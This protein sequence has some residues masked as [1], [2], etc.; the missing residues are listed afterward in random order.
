MVGGMDLVRDLILK[1]LDAVRLTMS[2]ASLRIGRNASYLQQFIKRGIPAELHERDRAQLAILL[3][4]SED[5]LRGSGTP[6]P[7]RPYAKNDESRS[8]TR[9]YEG[10]IGVSRQNLVASPMSFDRVKGHELPVYGTAQSGRGA[11]IV[12]KSLLIGRRVPIFCP[13]MKMPMG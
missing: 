6:L 2:A 10:G 3:G 13:V 11:V 4:I 9:D 12:T 8:R 7:P 1:R 5:E